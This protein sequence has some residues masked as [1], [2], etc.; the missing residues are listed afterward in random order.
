MSGNWWR[1]WC[2]GVLVAGLLLA[3]MIPMMTTG[4]EAKT[5]GKRYCFLGVCH[6]VL[7]LRQTRQA[8]GKAVKVVASHYDDARRDR[9]N[10]RNLTSSGAY[11]RA[12]RPDNAASPI[13]PDGTVLLAW[14]PATKKAV[15]VRVNN[16]G[17]YYKNRK[18]DVSRAAAVKLG[19]AHRGVARLV[20]RVLKAP[21]RAEARYRRGR[22]YAPVAGYIGRFASLDL[23][24]QKAGLGYRLQDGGPMRFAGVPGVP[25]AHPKRAT[26]MMA[27][28]IAAPRR[29]PFALAVLARVARRGGLQR[30]RVAG[31]GPHPAF[32][33]LAGQAG[34]RQGHIGDRRRVAGRVARSMRDQRHEAF[35][36]QARAGL[37]M[38]LDRGVMEPGVMVGRTRKLGVAHKRIQLAAMQSARLGPLESEGKGNRSTGYRRHKSHVGA[39]AKSSASPAGA[40]PSVGLSA[41]E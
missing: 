18:L 7:T 26:K 34:G 9:F 22:R 24:T 2:V 35:A 16:A 3:P 27:V 15:V 10:P 6:R 1:S 31:E 30:R 19:F 23:A 40:V 36:G 39:G 32:A 28:R 25:S 21:S 4:A 33:V 37:A 20:V 14:N 13:Y 29:K 8:I 12:S 11:F 41:S 17:P 38:S 5:P